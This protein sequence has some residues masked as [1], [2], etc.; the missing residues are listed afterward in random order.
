MIACLSILFDKI[1]RK[2][3][4]IANPS[5]TPSKRIFVILIAYK[6]PLWVETVIDLLNKS[7]EPNNVSIGI[8][9][10]V[11]RVSESMEASLPEQY[12][13]NV[14]IYA[15]ASRVAK[16]LQQA[17]KICM[18]KLYKDEEYVL[19][20]EDILPIPKWDTYLKDIHSGDT[21]IST[22]LNDD[23]PRFMT[24]Q[25]DN[26]IKYKRIKVKSL[27]GTT[28][29][30]GWTAQFSFSRANE[31]LITLEKD[32]MWDVTAH[33][34]YHKISIV[35]PLYFWARKKSVHRL[36]CKA[37]VQKM[38]AFLEK[39]GRPKKLILGLTVNATN[40][41]KIIKYGSLSAERILYQSL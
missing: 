37:S 28:P 32:D 22:L 23:K 27:S 12:R 41:E 2:R 34:Y 40:E 7:Q 3:L 25:N 9:E 31:A 6:N 14:S 16:N 30:I 39:I 5:D 11:E 36:K 35:C 18:K 10:Y 1:R 26:T 24:I 8:V 33:L 4:P 20:T 17:R 13:Q 19:M 21:I 15:M 29:V 38:N